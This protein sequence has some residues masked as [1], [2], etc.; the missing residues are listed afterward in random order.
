M[1][2]PVDVFVG[3]KLRYQR[4]VQ[5]LSQ[6]ELAQKVGVTFQ[7]IQKY[8][9]GTNR[10]SS[11]RLFEFATILEVAIDFFF[12]GYHVDAS[13]LATGG[14]AEAGEPY[15]SE[16]KTIANDEFDRDT[17]ALIQ[18]FQKV[19]DPNVRQRILGLLRSLMDES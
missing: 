14:F 5:G 12:R 18:V 16:E 7:Q 9:R 13:E 1:P 8:E 2:H 15:Q 3:K 10:V 4:N 19:K 11:S 17:L 6:Q